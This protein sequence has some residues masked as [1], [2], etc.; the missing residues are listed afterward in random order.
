MIKN[1]LIALA[2][3]L[4][5]VGSL[6]MFVHP[7]SLVIKHGYGSNG[8]PSD[9]YINPLWFANGISV[10][11]TGTY[12]LNSQFGSCNPTFYGTSLAAT[13]TGTF[14]C[15][16][17]GIKAGD[18]ILADAATNTGV[19]LGGFV[20]ENAYATTTGII[21]FTYLNLT[22]TASSSFAQATTGVE[23]STSR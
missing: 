19:T 13:S 8:E 22:G 14:I 3:V 21:A 7:A 20:I 15:N 11:P 9:A 5:F 17:P 12:N 2:L 10:G 18:L 4:G 16:V 23:Y 1:L 6:S